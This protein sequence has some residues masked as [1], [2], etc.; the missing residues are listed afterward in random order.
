MSSESCL[1]AKL[2]HYIELTEEEADFLRSLELD[3]RRYQRGDVIRN[4]GEPADELFIVKSGWVTL[5]TLLQSGRRLIYDIHFP[6]DLLGSRDVVLSQATVSMTAATDVV[7]CPFPKSS[8]DDIFAGWPRISALLFSLSIL[9]NTT[10]FDRLRAVARMD[11]S[12]RLGFFLLQILSRL[13]VTNRDH[14]DTMDL[15]L[16]QELIGDALGLSQVHVNRTMRE[17]E[18]GGYV[19]RTERGRI[20]VSFDRL[21]ELSEFQEARYRVDLSWMPKN[22]R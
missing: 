4:E 5:W 17:L 10:V 9:E 12:Q 6:G 19:T 3:E 7:V 11:A 14:P 15:P 21:A 16:S 1:V 18:E 8:L 2:R 13:R 20:T 22:P